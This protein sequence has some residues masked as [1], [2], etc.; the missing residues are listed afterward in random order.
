MHNNKE[1]LPS[2]ASQRVR[3]ATSEHKKF[4]QNTFIPKYLIDQNNVKNL[5]NAILE[6]GSGNGDTAVNF[7]FNN[8]EKTYIACEVFLDGVIQMA[9]KAFEKNLK[10]L[11][12]FMEDARNL[13][14]N[15]E[16]GALSCLFI[17]FPD[18]WPKKKHNKRRILSDKFLQLAHSKLKNDGAI[19][20]ATDHSSYK[21]YIEEI[22]KTQKLFSFSKENF[23]DWWTVTKYQKKALAEGRESNF[24]VFK[25]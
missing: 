15:L 4:L 19:F 16:N 21:E 25:K 11:H 8:K 17:F 3:G 20:M 14:I 13:M 1:F 23:P 2:F 24:F 10:N 5:K 12:F 6:I 22:G 9:G 7:A 18:P